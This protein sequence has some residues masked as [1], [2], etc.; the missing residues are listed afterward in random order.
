MLGHDDDPLVKDDT[1]IPRDAKV[2]L[3]AVMCIDVD[4]NEWLDEDETEITLDELRRRFVGLP[5]RQVPSDTEIVEVLRK[6]LDHEWGDAAW[7]AGVDEQGALSRPRFEW[8]WEKERR[9]RAEKSPVAA[10][11][12]PTILNR[13]T[14]PWEA[15]RG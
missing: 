1:M 14:D 4:V 12:I 8:P 3:R 6:D 7:F 2:E 9:A 15:Q 13:Y 11:G 10:A 5:S